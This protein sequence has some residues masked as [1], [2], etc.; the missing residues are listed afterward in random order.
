M[1]RAEVWRAGEDLAASHLE[2]LGWTILERNWRCPAGELDI[3]A[4]QHRPRPVV[5]FCEVKCRR[6]LAYGP[7]LESI[8]AAKLGKL[9]E[10][11]LHW[12]RSQDRPIGQF[13]LDG[14]GVLLHRD[15]PPEI[16]HL[17][18]IG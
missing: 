3:I 17:R 5:V 10:L 4:V 6:G 9:R 7:P 1:G 15:R 2:K 14:I 8:T 16:T 12:L 11:A 13:R 18:G